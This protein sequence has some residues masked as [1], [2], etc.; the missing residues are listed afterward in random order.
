VLRW[1]RP[2]LEVYLNQDPGFAPFFLVQPPGITFSS[3][4]E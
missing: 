1:V 3:E 2:F 4:T